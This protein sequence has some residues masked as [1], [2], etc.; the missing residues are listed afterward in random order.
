MK[1]YAIGQMV[2]MKKGHPSQCADPPGS[3]WTPYETYNWRNCQR[4]QL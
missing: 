2:E 4:F 1:N 3:F